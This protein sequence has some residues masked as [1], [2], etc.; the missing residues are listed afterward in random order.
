MDAYTNLK[1]ETKEKKKMK[2]KLLGIFVILILLKIL[3]AVCIPVPLG[4]SDSLT[5]IDG[6][7]A[8]FSNPS[9]SS[10][11]STQKYTLFPIISSMFLFITDM[12]RV[13][14][15]I[16][17][18]NAILSSL[19]IFP[20]Y[21]LAREFLEEKESALLATVIAVL[22]AVFISSYY[23]MSEALFYLLL[24]TTIYCIFKAYTE[25][26]ILW[27]ILTGV[28]LGLTFL[29]K[30][31]AII[32][33]PMIIILFLK[34]IKNK[35]WGIVKNK[36]LL[37]ITSLTVL[38]PFLVAKAE[39]NGFTLSGIFGY[40][41]E[42]QNITQGTNIFAKILW[43]FFYTDYLLLAS[44]LLSVL[45]LFYALTKYKQ[46]TEKEKVLLQ[47]VLWLSLGVILLAANNGS[48]FAN[49]NDTRVIGRY[50]ELA[51][52]FLLLTSI[53]F[54]KDWKRNWDFT[55]III[56]A[57]V[58]ITT[59]FILTK[60]LF[61]L[62]NAGLSDIGALQIFLQILSIPIWVIII[63]LLIIT[64]G[65]MNTRKIKQRKYL[66]IL[67]IYF[68]L[69][70]LLCTAM[71]IYDTNKNW[72]SLEEVRLGKWINTN[73]DKNASFL[74]DETDMPQ[75]DYR[76]KPS[77]VTQTKDRPLTVIAYWIY[78]NYV[79]TN[80]SEANA[81]DYVI[82]TQDLPYTIVAQGETIKIYEVNTT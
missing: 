14:F 44:G 25:K 58:S 2:K 20:M 10:A 65:I 62:N 5:H 28:L 33:L 72:E 39:K 27:D 55:K 40:S 37:G 29:T 81:Y 73:L 1:K 69:T 68:L 15:L 17:I 32:L 45:I 66:S 12:N 63:P 67:F 74:I 47:I 16:M 52:P 13:Y 46:K 57:L 19:L 42:V 11:I 23:V 7:K 64:I 36:T 30:A 6:A 43:T 8:F 71:I 4:F 38:L 21:Q 49:I 51:I 76:D 3:L 77:D 53:V 56:I 60:A 59:P 79:V 70:S 75:V 34:A 22:P 31:S 41:S 18:L 61:P 78:G 80:I 82:S 24:I 48:H 9:F 35:E 54:M 26:R 50:V